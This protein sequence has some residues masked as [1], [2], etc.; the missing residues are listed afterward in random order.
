MKQAVT[1]FTAK[2][3]R[4]LLRE[5]FT[6]IDVKPDKTDLDGKRSLFIFKNEDGLMESVREGRFLENAYNDAC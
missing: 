2:M 1:I 3:A 6:I 5:G 4:R